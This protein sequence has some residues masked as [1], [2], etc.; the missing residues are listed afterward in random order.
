MLTDALL[1][2]FV[3]VGEGQYMDF[4]LAASPLG[5]AHATPEWY[6]EMIG[7]KSGALVGVAAFAAGIIARKGETEL[8]SLATFGRELGTAYQMLDDLRSIEE[9]RE[10]TG[11]DTHSDIREHKRTLPVLLA[12]QELA[13]GDAARLRALYELGRQLEPVEIDEALALIGK[14]RARATTRSRIAEKLEVVA[15]AAQSLSITSEKKGQ[16]VDFARTLVALG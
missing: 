1:R 3:E 10:S 14:T 2:A 6:E 15:A 7:K 8:E 4:E 16:L 5:G 11:K 9:T 13:A 12:L